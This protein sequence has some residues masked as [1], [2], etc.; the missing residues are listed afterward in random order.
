MGQS[1]PGL[2]VGEF[3][4]ELLG[5]GR[6]GQPEVVRRA[7]GCPHSS[8]L[9][10][11]ED[12]QADSSVSPLPLL[13][14]KIHQTHSLARLLTKYAEQLFQEYLQKLGLQ[15]RSVTCPRPHSTWRRVISVPQRPLHPPKLGGSL[16]A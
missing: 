5:S 1:L 16:G 7:W 4:A 10:P 14:A 12:P 6:K 8:P 3:R 9:F 2:K 11:P 13:E 15:E